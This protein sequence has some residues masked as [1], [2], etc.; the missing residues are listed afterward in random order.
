M[1]LV[2]TMLTCGIYYLYW[3]YATSSELKEAL[4][5]EEIKP[6]IDLLLTIVTCYLWAIYLEHRNAQRVH[7]ALLSRDPYAKDQSEI[8][9]ILNVCAVFVG[10]TWL[11]ATYIL[12]EE[13]N[14]LTRL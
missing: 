14:K 11:I 13:Y 3:V 6:G 9:L 10:V 5:D 8:I 7:A 4:G 12:Q 2:L 1:V